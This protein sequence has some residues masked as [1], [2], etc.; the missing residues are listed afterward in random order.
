M[1][2]WSDDKKNKIFW[3]E[4]SLRIFKGGFYHPFGNFK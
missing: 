3:N 4:K 2:L 1:Y